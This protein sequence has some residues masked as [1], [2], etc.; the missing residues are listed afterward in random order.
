MQQSM[1]PRIAL[2][3]PGLGRERRGYERITADIYTIL[4]DD[5]DATLFKGGGVAGPKEIVPFSL[6]RDGWVLMNLHLHKLIG[7]TRYHME[8]LTFA[9]SLVPHLL[10]GN[11]DVVFTYDPPMLKPLYWLRKLIGGHFRILFGH[12]GAFA[13]NY[14]PHA[15]VVLHCTPVWHELDVKAGVPES[16]RILL[17]LGIRPERFQVQASKAELRRQYGVPESTLLVLSISALDRKQKRVDHLIEEVSKVEGE[18]LLW[19]DGSNKFSS[20]LTLVDLAKERLGDRCRLTYSPSE[21][22]GELL[23]MADVMVLAS[24]MEGFGLVLVEALCT[25]T[26][27]LSHNGSHFEWL[28][29]KSDLLVDMTVPGALAAKLQPLVEKHDALRTLVDIDEYRSRYAWPNL[30]PAYLNLFRQVAQGQTP[31]DR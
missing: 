3:C 4:R 24:T 14:W 26:P 12:G 31:H 7:R 21:K 30:K 28:I 11:F 5:L 1:R 8:C 20:D 29:G 2:I 9:L 18:V 23:A 6:A 15:D 27:T 25:G 22:V 10:R 16:N 13:F 19:I 17:P